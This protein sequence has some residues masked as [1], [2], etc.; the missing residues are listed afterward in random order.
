MRPLASV[1]VATPV[2]VAVIT[3]S[4]SGNAGFKS[5]VQFANVPIIL[6]CVSNKRYG[7]KDKGLK[8]ITPPLV[9]PK[10]RPR[11]DMPDY[12]CL[13][14]RTLPELRVKAVI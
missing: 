12:T 11:R 6:D 10:P 5:N 13:Y 4:V 3:S 9:I 8:G 1:N 14:A 7:S 2:R